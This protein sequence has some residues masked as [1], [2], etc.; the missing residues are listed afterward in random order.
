MKK[1]VENRCDKD[2]YKERIK[3]NYSAG[4]TEL[5]VKKI[6]TLYNCTEYPQ[7]FENDLIE[8]EKHNSHENSIEKDSDEEL[9]SGSVTIPLRNCIKYR[10]LHIYVETFQVLKTRKASTYIWR[11]LYTVPRSGSLT[12]KSIAASNQSDF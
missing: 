10:V 5:D 9:A 8:D 7:L 12:L 11:I 6:D 1:G 2:I 3:G 4:L